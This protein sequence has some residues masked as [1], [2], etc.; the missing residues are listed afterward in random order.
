LPAA[1]R[2]PLRLLVV[3][4]AAIVYDT[5]PDPVPDPFTVIQDVAVDALHVQP[6]GAVTVSV[7]VPPAAP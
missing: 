4:F 7:P 2:L 5:V 6:A 1:T 3:R